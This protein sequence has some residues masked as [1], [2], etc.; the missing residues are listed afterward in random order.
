MSYKYKIMAYIDMSIVPKVKEILDE[1]NGHMHSFDSSFPSIGMT[2]TVKI[3][4]LTVA[5]QLSGSDIMTIINIMQDQFNKSENLS[6]IHITH[7][8]QE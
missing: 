4:E 7:L 2:S 5:K 1:L 6:K 3:G 8:E